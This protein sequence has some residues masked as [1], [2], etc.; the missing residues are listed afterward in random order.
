MERRD[1]PVALSDGGVGGV[2]RMPVRIAS[3][4]CANPVWREGDAGGFISPK[5]RVQSFAKADE[6]GEFREF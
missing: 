3:A 6:R 2:S 5:K 1:D 4:L